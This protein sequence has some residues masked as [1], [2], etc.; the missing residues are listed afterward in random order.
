MFSQF[1]HSSEDSAVTQ[2]CHHCCS[3]CILEHVR[4]FGVFGGTAVF[5]QED[6]ENVSEMG[7]CSV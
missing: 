3:V 2:D 5:I 1:F 4:T 7:F 6:Q